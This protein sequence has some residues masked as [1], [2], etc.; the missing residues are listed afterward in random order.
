MQ[1]QLNLDMDVLQG[2]IV[3]VNKLAGRPQ[4]LRS[5]NIVIRVGVTLSAP[6]ALF[7]DGRLSYLSRERSAYTFHSLRATLQKR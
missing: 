4:Y 7:V 1:F 6:F 5:K 2:S 3:T